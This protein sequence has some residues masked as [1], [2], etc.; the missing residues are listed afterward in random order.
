MQILCTLHYTT[1]A[2]VA[3]FAFRRVIMRYI[4]GI[5]FS[6]LFN[7]YRR[8]KYAKDICRY[9]LFVVELRQIDF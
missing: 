4:A 9:Q 1:L 7:Y 2:Y 5:K 3:L 6:A 8:R